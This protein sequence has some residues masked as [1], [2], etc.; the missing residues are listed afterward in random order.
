MMA[1]VFAALALLVLVTLAC[2][3]AVDVIDALRIRDRERWER[4]IESQ[5]QLDRDFADLLYPPKRHR[6][7]RWMS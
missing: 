2:R 3:A 6:P 4:F 7:P 1:I 5:R